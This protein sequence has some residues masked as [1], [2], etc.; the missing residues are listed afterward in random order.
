MVFMVTIQLDPLVEERLKQLAAARGQ[1]AAQLV[2]RIVE[3]YLDYQGW[4]QDSVEDWA[5]ASLALAP[6]VFPEETWSDEDSG[7]GSR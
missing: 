1:V 3:E 5:A 4:T 2:Q 6:E 7:H